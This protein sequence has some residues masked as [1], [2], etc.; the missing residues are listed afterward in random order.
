MTDILNDPTIRMAIRGQQSKDELRAKLASLL[1]S[2]KTWET[3]TANERKVC[4][5]HIVTE[6]ESEL[7]LSRRLNDLGC[8]DCAINW[9]D[10]DPSDKTGLEAQALVKALGGLVAKNGALVSVMTADEDF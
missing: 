8:T 7:E 3:M 5:Q 1:I 10:V 6:V 2:T 9:H 4:V